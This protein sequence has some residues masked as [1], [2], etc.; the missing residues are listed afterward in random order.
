MLVE[1]TQ[2]QNLQIKQLKAQADQIPLTVY[3]L[4]AKE[5][6]A[7]R[8]VFVVWK[9]NPIGVLNLMIKNVAGK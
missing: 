7:Q 4:K 1:L 2:E 9:N 3:L 8:H 5:K 6:N